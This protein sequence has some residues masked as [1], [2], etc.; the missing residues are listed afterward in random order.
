MTAHA[1]LASF[2]ALS[3]GHPRTTEPGQPVR[4]GLVGRLHVSEPYLPHR[5]VAAFRGLTV[6][7]RTLQEKLGGMGRHLAA[8]AAKL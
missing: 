1:S 6:R 7:Y 5:R 2:V 4:G 3:F 8:R